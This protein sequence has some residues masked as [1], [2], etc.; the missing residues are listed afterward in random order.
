MFA[1]I[2]SI[3]IT[4]FKI[5]HTSSHWLGLAFLSGV[6]LMHLPWLLMVDI[7][8]IISDDSLDS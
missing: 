7:S 4:R 5:D 8:N 2:L 6:L 3:T 1:C